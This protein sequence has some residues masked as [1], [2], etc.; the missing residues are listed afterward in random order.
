MEYCGEGREYSAQGSRRLSDSQ[1][2]RAKAAKY[3][4]EREPRNAEAS[5]NVSS[6]MA[7]RTP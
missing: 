7:Q 5:R 2:L 1:P 6:W 3:R 4:G